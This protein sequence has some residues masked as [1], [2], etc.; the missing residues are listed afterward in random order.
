LAR[1][2]SSRDNGFAAGGGVA[3]LAALAFGAGTG[4]AAGARSLAIRWLPTVPTM[5]S[6]FCVIVFGRTKSYAA[7]GCVFGGFKLGTRALLFP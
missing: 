2:C 4:V 1:S 5:G 3:G 6:P 7:N